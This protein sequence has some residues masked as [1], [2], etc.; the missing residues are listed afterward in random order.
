MVSAVSLKSAQSKPEA[1]PAARASGR[2]YLGI[3]WDAVADMLWLTRDA[4]R[5]FPAGIVG[6]LAAQVTGQM[7]FAGA[8]TQV[9]LYVRAVERG[10]HYA[11]PKS[12][13][14]EMSGTTLALAAAGAAL[15][16]FGA[17][18]SLSFWGRLISTR[19]VRR[20][21]DT[22]AKACLEAV[23]IGSWPIS[24]IGQ[25]LTDRQLLRM[26]TKDVRYCGRAVDE[27][28]GA[29][30]PLFT[31][32][33][34]F[35]T[36]V[37]LDW[38]LSLVLLLMTA[39][40]A[41]AYMMVNR[42][43]RKSMRAIERYASEDTLLK[44]E[45]IGRSKIETSPAAL[46]SHAAQELLDHD[47]HRHYLD[48]YEFRLRAAHSSIYVSNLLFATVFCVLLLYFGLLA[49]TAEGAGYSILAFVLAAQYFLVS[50]RGV[51][52]SG[53]NL[54]MFHESFCR[55]SRFLSRTQGT[56]RTAAATLGD[57]IRVTAEPL[58][59]LE[60]LG[61]IQVRRGSPVA[62]IANQPLTR[63]ACTSVV[64]G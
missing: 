37:Y 26:L 1:A 8:L 61:D 62:V 39:V 58:P 30:T 3:P 49:P 20:Y 46:S 60:S 43:G 4:A 13:P 56:R 15:L 14:I 40:G 6:A 33:I 22:C 35:A 63:M 64:G 53:A 27:L 24:D 44:Q 45:L 17:S 54:S 21:E 25:P 5:R 2:R 48:G 42:R 28:I 10:K 34:S 19:L 18:A 16:L 57:S 59:G 36:L 50:V 47:S 9:V 12:I 23:A 11:L 29:I 55:V 7:L 31:M 32:L 52:K 51:A 41:P 38:R